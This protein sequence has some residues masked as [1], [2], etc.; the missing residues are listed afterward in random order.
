M[1]NTMFESIFKESEL[2]P[3]EKM[4][5]WHD[6]S[7]R[8]NLSAASAE[9]L[10]NNLDICKEK[11]YDAEIEK[12]KA[13]LK[14]RGLKINEALDNDKENTSENEEKTDYVVELVGD[15]EIQNFIQN[16]DNVSNEDYKKCIK[17][18]LESK[19]LKD[20]DWIINPVTA[21]FYVLSLVEDGDEFAK[22]L[23]KI[24]E[25]LETTEK[26]I[27][28]DTNNEEDIGICTSSEVWDKLGDGKNSVDYCIISRDRS[29]GDLNTIVLVYNGKTVY[30]LA[31]FNE[32][33][34]SENLQNYFNE[35]GQDK[36]AKLYIDMLQKLDDADAFSKNKSI[37]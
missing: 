3:S 26:L 36:M 8:F 13:E 15:K 6:G 18:F 24:D 21:C 35:I 9:K 23:T 10:R 5:K 32:D 30:E 25:T 27:Y 33:Y 19:P 12:I 16:L 14:K 34:V 17:A 28:R 11:G 37:L 2:S 31:S 4:D 20:T 22:A 1:D 29:D 7:R